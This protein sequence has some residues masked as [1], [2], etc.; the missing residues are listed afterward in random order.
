MQL[1]TSTASRL[2]VKNIFD[3][4]ENIDAGTHYL[5]DLLPMYKNDLALGLPAYNAG[6]EQVLRHGQ[7]VPP[8]A[9]TISYIKPVR[10]TY[11]QRKS[12]G[13]SAAG[14]TPVHAAPMAAA[15]TTP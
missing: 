15:T 14:K 2:G 9:E 4:Q 3:P 10:Q 8:F 13:P 1:L 12:N 6:P 11:N 5:G 7:P